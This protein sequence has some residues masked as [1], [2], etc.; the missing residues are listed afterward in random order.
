MPLFFRE[1][2]LPFYNA[3]KYKFKLLSFDE[4]VINLDRLSR[5]KLPDDS[6]II[7]F[8]SIL[9]KCLISPKYSKAQLEQLT[10]DIISNLVKLIWNK[11]VINLFPNYKN[12]FQTNKALK[13]LATIPFKNIDN[14][15]KVLLNTKLILS[16]ILENICYESAPI[17]L[18]FLIQVNSCFSLS[19]PFKKSNIDFFRKKYALKFPIKKLLIVEGITEEIL[20]PVFAK[21]LGFDFNK[22]GIFVLG[23]GGKSKSPDIYFKLKDKLRIPIFLLFDSDAD[24]ICNSLN[25]IILKKDKIVI[26]KSG[27]FEDIISLN[28]I[29]RALNLEYEM[30]S[31]LKKDDLHIYN[32]MC[33]N[34]EYFYRTRNIGEFK[35]AK[36]SKIIAKNIKYSSDISTEIKDIIFTLI[37]KKRA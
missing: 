27:E 6:Y 4:L 24:Q 28:L 7:V 1:F 13:Y 25:K 36:F 19:N 5:F 15:T 9:S 23:A 16:P 18:K 20:I 32:K 21:K 30:I 37:N 26:I 22:E 31:P 33:E 17:N 35:K 29:K 12:N 34:L 10:A 3:N 14:N 11:S 2:F 8:Y